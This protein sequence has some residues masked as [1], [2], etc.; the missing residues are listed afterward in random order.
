MFN[1]EME[2]TPKEIDEIKNILRKEGKKDATDEDARDLHYRMVAL[3]D[4]VIDVAVD[5]ARKEKK[6]KENPDGFPLD[7]TYT[8]LLCH[9]SAN[10]ETGWWDKVGPL[11]LNC[12]DAVRKRVITRRDIK[13]KDKA[14]YTDWE[15][16]Y[17]FNIHPATQRKA[18]RDGRLKARVVENKLGKPH[19]FVYLIRENQDYLP[20]P[21]PGYNRVVRP[22]DKKSFRAVPVKGT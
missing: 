7:N 20:S 12:R 2:P 19:L 4:I 22:G 18:I 17:Y 15:L 1:S 6:L 13:N 14:M 8:C 21:K 16:K 9:D 10:Q 11:C 5:R 3:A